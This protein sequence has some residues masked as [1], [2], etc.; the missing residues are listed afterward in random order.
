[1]RRITTQEAAK[2]VG[3]SRATLQA[4]IAA[5]KVRAPK[6]QIIHGVAARIWK[7]PDLK[8]LS[9]AKVKLYRKGRGRKPKPKSKRLKSK[10]PA[11]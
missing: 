10:R 4:W 8:R 3:I 1:M 5:G 9:A 7:E 6:V 11:G 2:T